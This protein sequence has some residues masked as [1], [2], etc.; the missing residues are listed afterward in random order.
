MLWEVRETIEGR[1]SCQ[2]PKAKDQ[3]LRGST[4]SKEDEEI[5]PSEKIP[6]NHIQ[7]VEDI[8]EDLDFDLSQE[9]ELF[10]TP[11]PEGVDAD[12]QY[13]EQGLSKAAIRMRKHRAAMTEEEKTKQRENARLRM[14]A[15]R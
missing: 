8:N 2:A 12:E 11:L 14:Q 10:Y 6:E 1:G 7:E 3:G 15:H 9:N 13:L 4:N 5:D